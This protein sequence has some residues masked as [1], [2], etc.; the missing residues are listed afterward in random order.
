MDTNIYQV[1]FDGISSLKI[2]KW[3]KILFLAVYTDTSFEM[4]FYVYTNEKYVDCFSL[5]IPMPNIINLFATLD[6]DI[7]IH[8][9]EMIDKWSSMTLSIGE[10]GEFNVNYDY[11]SLYEDTIS[12]INSWKEKYIK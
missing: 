11:D 5:G 4:K 9:N 12:Y 2:P 6:K 8:R 3:K 10:S 1:I 7:A